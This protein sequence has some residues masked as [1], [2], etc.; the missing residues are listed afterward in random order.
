MQKSDILE[1]PLAFQN[2]PDKYKTQDMCIKAVKEKPELLE[3][4]TNKHNIKE[5]Y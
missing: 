5:M 1:D 2:F 3:F 4:V